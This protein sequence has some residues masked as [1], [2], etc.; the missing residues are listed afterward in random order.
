MGHLDGSRRRRRSLC[1]MTDRPSSSPGRNDLATRQLALT[2]PL[3]VPG[4]L[5]GL[6][7]WGDDLIDRWDGRRWL[8]VLRIAGRSVPARAHVAG[9]LAAP[10]LEVTAAAPDLDAVAGHFAATFVTVEVAELQA[11]AA[12]DPAVAAADAHHPG[13]R[14]LLTHETFDALVRS[15]SAQQ[16][17]LRW[18]AETRRRLALRYGE[19]HE[20]LGE[21]VVALDPAVLADAS[22]D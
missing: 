20:I 14:P 9:S 21:T 18:A 7:R 17:N 22:V 10:V 1:R 6:Q 8:R 16:V 15:I 5:R 4:S 12:T 11:L 13:I 19:P 2:A 3:D